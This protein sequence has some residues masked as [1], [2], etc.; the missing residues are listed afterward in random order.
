MWAG[1]SLAGLT[2]CWK[3]TAKRFT[4]SLPVCE[5][6]QTQSRSH[7]L[8]W[9]HFRWPALT[10]ATRVLA[11]LEW[12]HDA[13]D[14]H[15]FQDAVSNPLLCQD[16]QSDVKLRICEWYT[17]DYRFFVN[18][19]V[20]LASLRSLAYAIFTLRKA[21]CTRWVCYLESRVLVFVT[22]WAESQELKLVPSR[23]PPLQDTS[24]QSF[25]NFWSLIEKRQRNIS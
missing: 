11:T 13:A 4:A 2:C 14:S 18:L 23:G 15:H 10:L 21:C 3:Y 8:E 20:E 19:E 9:C 1:L 25:W 16:T 22:E 7:S 6:Q 17:N 5:W 12:G 24:V